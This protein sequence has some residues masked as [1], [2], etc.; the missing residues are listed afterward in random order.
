MEDAE[1]V[2]TSFVIGAEVQAMRVFGFMAV[3]QVVVK[4]LAETVF[5]VLAYNVFLHY[6]R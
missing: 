3:A 1:S 4:L 6:K 5:E 2:L